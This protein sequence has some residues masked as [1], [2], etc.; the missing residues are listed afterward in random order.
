MMNALKEY[1][2]TVCRPAWKWV[3]K[4]WKGYS[5]FLV[6]CMLGPYVWFYWDEIRA[7]IKS[8]FKKKDDEES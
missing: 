1:N 3:G 5:V 8:K 4:H 6:I 7:F 2:E